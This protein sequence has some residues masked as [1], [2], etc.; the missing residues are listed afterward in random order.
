MLIH[1]LRAIRLILSPARN[2]QGRFGQENFSLSCELQ[3]A[4]SKRFSQHIRVLGACGWPLLPRQLLVRRGTRQTPDPLQ[5]HC[6]QLFILLPHYDS[7]GKG[8]TLCTAALDLS[9]STSLRD[10]WVVVPTIQ[11]SRGN[12]TTCPPVAPVEDTRHWNRTTPHDLASRRIN[13]AN[14]FSL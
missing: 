11:S 14:V 2:A 4:E 6:I 10:S 1:T 12:T 8:Q 7:S 5:P 13:Q 9:P 3:C